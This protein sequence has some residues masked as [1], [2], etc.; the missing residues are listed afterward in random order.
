MDSKICYSGSVV[1]GSFFPGRNVK[2]AKKISA[3]IRGSLVECK[4]KAASLA[5]NL[6]VT[7]ELTSFSSSLYLTE[8]QTAELSLI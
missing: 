6:R 3:E 2:R 8:L 7:E 4:V 5:Q 1:I